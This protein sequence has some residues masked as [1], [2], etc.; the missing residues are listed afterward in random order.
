MI[1]DIAVTMGNDV[2]GAWRVYRFDGV[3]IAA[4]DL[5]YGFVDGVNIAAE[6][7]DSTGIDG[8]V[9]GERGGSGVWFVSPESLTPR[10]L[11]VK[12]PTSRWAVSTRTMEKGWT[13]RGSWPR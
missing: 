12:P 3:L 13:V 10:T 7:I 8:L 4:G 2:H 9:L 6:D 11:S 5:G 1:P